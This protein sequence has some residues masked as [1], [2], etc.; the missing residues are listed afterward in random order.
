M[1]NKF[2][3]LRAMTFC[4]AIFRVY[5]FFSPIHSLL[6]RRLRRKLFNTESR[7]QLNNTYLNFTQ[8]EAAFFHVL[9]CRTFYEQTLN[10]GNFEWEVNFLG[11]HLKMPIHS[12][13]SWLDWNLATAILGHDIEVKITYETLL[14]ADT[15]PRVFYDVGANYGTHSLLF[16]AHGLD[17]A[18]FEPNPS[19]HEFFRQ[20]FEMNRFVPNIVAAAV[21]D[22][23]GETEFWFPECETW[24]GTMDQK[25]KQSLS[26]GGFDLKKIKVAVTTLDDYVRQGA[27]PPDIIKIDTEGNELKVLQG[28]LMI[29]EI[30]RPFIIFESNSGGR[31][32]LWRFFC[33]QRYIIAGL[34]VRDLGCVIP[35]TEKEFVTNIEGNFIAISKC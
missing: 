1:L 8:L 16:R 12:K 27:A 31:D 7:S 28:A 19:C 29:L 10:I 3:K 6:N 17:V 9:Y 21:S 34:P 32:E 14:Q 22:K 11:K 20:I 25:V 2:R 13:T 23:T 15:K 24:L 5:V 26:G 30:A 4:E 35:L 18:A 33:E